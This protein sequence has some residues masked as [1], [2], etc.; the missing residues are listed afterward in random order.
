MDSIKNQRFYKFRSNES[1]YKLHLDLKPYE[2]YE[3]IAISSAAIPKTYYVLPNDSVIDLNENG[4]ITEIHISKGNYNVISL[5]SILNNL[6][7]SA[8]WTYTVSYPSDYKANQTGKITF[9][10]ENNTTQ[11]IMTVSNDLMPLLG[12]DT[13]TIAFENDQ[14]TS[15]LMLDFQQHKQ[16]Y[17]IS[18]VVANE[19]GLL[20]EIFTANDLYQSSIDF[21]NSN[22]LL[23]SKKKKLG[24]SEIEISLVD[25]Q[26]NKIDLN[27]A[28]WEVVL[29]CFNVKKT[30]ELI[31]RYINYRVE[32]DQ[33]N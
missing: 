23:F 22:L 1:T 18:N 33:L 31:E 8:L 20:Q 9:V 10:V 27:G 12:F 21:Q 26:N 30:N 13:N 3:Y 19:D 7:E 6:F 28:Y 17:L 5:I 29:C 25:F 15:K 4:N 14:L 11:P 32:T 24:F 16:L 2:D